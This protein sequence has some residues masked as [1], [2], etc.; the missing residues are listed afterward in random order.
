M[1][2]VE[3]VLKGGHAQVEDRYVGFQNDKQGRTWTGIMSRKGGDATD[4]WTPTRWTAPTTPSWLRGL[5]IPPSQYVKLA[6]PEGAASY[7]DVDYDG[8]LADIGARTGSHENEKREIIRKMT[9]GYD[10]VKQMETPSPALLEMVGPGPFPPLIVVEEMA[11]GDL[12]ALGLS[13]EKPSWF[14]E[15][16]EAQIIH[17]ARM[18][19]LF[20]AHQLRDLAKYERAKRQHTLG[21]KDAARVAKGETP[22][23]KDGE[24]TAKTTW[25]QFL[26]IGRRSGKTMEE[27]AEDWKDHKNSLEAAGV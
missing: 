7:I 15:A 12:W 25:S 27:C 19:N 9:D 5:F 18:T 3:V 24:I 20:Q 8:W 11:A 10:A 23:A 16:L 17:T 2:R 13:D 21:A 26:K 6:R 1:A 14:T 22:K 4:R